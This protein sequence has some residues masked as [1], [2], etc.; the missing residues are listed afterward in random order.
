[1]NHVFSD[2]TIKILRDFVESSPDSMIFNA[3]HRRYVDGD[4]HR[5]IELV[6]EQ[7]PA[8]HMPTEIGFSGW[9]SSP[10]AIHCIVAI[11]ILQGM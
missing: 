4:Q 2:Q 5:A 7:C 1:M 10:Q 9:G 8:D 3:L 6:R 11:S